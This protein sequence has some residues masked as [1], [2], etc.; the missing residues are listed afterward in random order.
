L[1]SFNDQWIEIFR[2]GNY[3]DKGEWSREK[4]SKVIQNFNDGIWTPPAVFGHPEEDSPAHGWVKDLVLDGDVLKAKF[5]QA[6]PQLEAAA[7]DGRFPN[8][9]AAFYFDPKGSGPV[10][11]HVGFLGGTPP[12]VKGLAPIRFSSTEFVSFDE[13]E[14]K[15]M[16]NDRT[17]IDP[18]SVKLRDRAREIQL[19]NST[20][21]FGEALSQAR[22]ESVTFEERENK[23]MSHNRTPT[24]PRSRELRDRAREIHLANSTMSFGEA[25]SQARRE[26]AQQPEGAAKIF[27][28][29]FD[30]MKANIGV[31][32]SEAFMYAF[33]ERTGQASSLLAH[34]ESVRL[35]AH[36]VELR[37][38]YPNLPPDQI[39]RLA[40]EQLY[41]QSESAV[42]ASTGVAA[43]QEGNAQWPEWLIAQGQQDGSWQQYVD[44]ISKAVLDALTAAQ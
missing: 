23:S 32:F 1:S 13:G 4:L 34:P 3:G 40:R 29:A 33:D 2:A 22:S 5:K 20:T 36:A 8:R 28:R 24:D 9:S 18:R 41:P 15:S 21:S 14:N 10:L 44:A 30:I 38:K 12:A 37:K 39:L 25:L 43:T 35:H 16:S 19:A 7:R 11:R 42:N 17:P 27:A 6:T 31:S 26:S